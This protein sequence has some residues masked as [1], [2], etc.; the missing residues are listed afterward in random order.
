MKNNFYIQW[1]KV[2]NKAYS[3]K[4]TECAK[5]FGLTKVELDILLFLSN[6]P[7][8]NTAKDIS[9]YR[10]ITKSHV[11]KSI[12]NLLEINYIKTKPS[13]ND[14][15]R[16]EIFL[17]PNSHKAVKAGRQLQD[18]FMEKILKNITDEEKIFLKNIFERIIKNLN[19]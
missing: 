12:E 3:A 16:I 19:E 4:I 7:D 10:S 11:S 1:N 13:E 9:T 2:F 14:K 8:Y 18:S 5:K 6:N 15:R 17:L